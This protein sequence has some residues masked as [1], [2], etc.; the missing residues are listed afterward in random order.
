MIIGKYNNRLYKEAPSII[1]PINKIYIQL[2]TNNYK[3]IN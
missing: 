1:K 2:Y 3:L